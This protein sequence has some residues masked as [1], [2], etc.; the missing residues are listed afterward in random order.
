M[1]NQFQQ[2]F[3]IL[4]KGLEMKNAYG[5]RILQSGPAHTHT[6]ARTQELTSTPWLQRLVATVNS[7]Q[8]EFSRHWEQTNLFTWD[9]KQL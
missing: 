5:L 2:Y 4:Q 8:Y 9:G 1:L 3:L 7:Y 6:H